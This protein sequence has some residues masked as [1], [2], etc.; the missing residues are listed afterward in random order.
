MELII[1]FILFVLLLFGGL[2]IPFALGTTSLVFLILKLGTPVLKGIGFVAWSSMDS[3]T[4]TA[5][6]L[7]I[8]ISEVL[9]RSGVGNRVY[10][11]FS[12]LVRP[13]PGGLLQTN[14]AGSAV[15]AAVSGSSV[16]TA[17]AIGTVAMPK[18]QEFGYSD[19]VSTGSLAA[20][21]TLGILIPPSI[22]FIVYGSFTDTSISKLF[23][24]GMIPGLVLAALFMLWIGISAV[25]WPSICPKKGAETHEPV[26]LLQLGADILPFGILIVGVLGGI[27]AGIVTPT[28][29]AA[30]G[31]GLA[32][33]IGVTIGNLTFRGF[34]ECL[35]ATIAATG[36][37]MFIVLCA[38]LFAYAAGITGIPQN[39]S[40]TLIDMG[41][42][43][44]QFLIAV[45]ILFLVLGMFMESFGIMVITVPLLLPL[46]QSYGFD[47]LWFGVLIV[48]LIEVGMITPPFGINLFVLQGI[49]TRGGLED[50]IIGVIPFCAIMLLMVGLLTAF[51]EL[52]TWLP[53]IM[54][55][56]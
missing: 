26:N 25:I 47:P 2:W 20:G 52:A 50:V 35:H 11:G 34:V 3:F 49:R 36:N 7:F 37:V 24:A 23:A 14:I 5:I 1:C 56:R 51:P 10:R 4:L 15:F 29:A 30:L 54:V 40:A 21:G 48:I 31:S 9:L 53:S 55:G 38:F 32:I 27:Y 6:P 39:L 43:S 8:L 12:V 44:G 22:A 18:L 13:V 19:R 33:I 17:A 46:I 45:I 28:E 41:L 16:A 42:T